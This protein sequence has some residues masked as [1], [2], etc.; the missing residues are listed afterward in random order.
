M[1]RKKRETGQAPFEKPFFL[2]NGGL[3]TEVSPLNAPEATTV[4]ELNMEIMRDGSRRRR[5]G[6]RQE[7]GGIPYSQSEAEVIGDLGVFSRANVYQWD[8]PGGDTSR[9]IQ[10]VKIGGT[11][12]FYN[13]DEILSANKLFPLWTGRLQ[14]ASR[15]L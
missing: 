1:P 8:S 3:N 7:I 13:D 10:V 9:T 4:D 12:H 6:I 11:L 15:M 5:R 2:L 14:T